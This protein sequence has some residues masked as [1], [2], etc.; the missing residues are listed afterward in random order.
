MVVVPWARTA[1]KAAE[2]EGGVGPD[3]GADGVEGE[4]Q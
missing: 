1:E 3:C 4:S 2:D